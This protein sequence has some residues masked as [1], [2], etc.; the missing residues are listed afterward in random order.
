MGQLQ[1]QHRLIYYQYSR[2]PRLTLTP[3]ADQSL[4]SS[5]GHMWKASKTRIKISHFKWIKKEKN[6]I[7]NVLTKDY[8]Q[9]HHLFISRVYAL[10]H[11]TPQGSHKA[12]Q[13]WGA[14]A[15]YIANDTRANTVSNN[16]SCGLPPPTAMR[17]PWRPEKDTDNHLWVTWWLSNESLRLE[18]PSWGRN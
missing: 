1:K 10:A 8:T 6:T 9:G 3:H 14:T 7:K 15:L 16:L 18:S 13:R 2:R 11:S 17:K 12:V 4:S 5:T